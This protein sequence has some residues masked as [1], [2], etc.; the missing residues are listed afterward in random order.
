MVSVGSM[1]FIADKPQPGMTLQ[2]L[3]AVCC[4]V[5]TWCYGSQ[6]AVNAATANGRLFVA[7][8]DLVPAWYGAE[9]SY[10]V[11]RALTQMQSLR[12]FNSPFSA[13]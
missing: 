9:H 10:F 11:L 2:I 1:S 3:L 6:V 8:S 5:G 12:K 13:Q 7:K 4:V